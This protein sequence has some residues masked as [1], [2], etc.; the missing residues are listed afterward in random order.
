LLVTKDGKI[1][2]GI[3]NM[4]LLVALAFNKGDQEFFKMLTFLLAETKQLVN[5]AV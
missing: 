5:R 2:E 4:Q 1:V 3:S